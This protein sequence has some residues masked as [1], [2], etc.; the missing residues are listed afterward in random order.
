MTAII[1]Y[2]CKVKG[3]QSC[4]NAYYCRSLCLSPHTNQILCFL[5]LLLQMYHPEGMCSRAAGSLLDHCGRRPPAVSL[6][7][8]DTSG[9]QHLSRHQGTINSPHAA[10]AVTFSTSHTDMAADLYRSYG[11]NGV[12]VFKAGFSDA[13][14]I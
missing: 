13:F 7:H 8:P 6:H 12:T 4:A 14:I 11:S 3:E 1:L 9:D 5:F 2:D 10:V